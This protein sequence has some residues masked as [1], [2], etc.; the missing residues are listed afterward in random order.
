MADGSEDEVF[1]LLKPWQ[2]LICECFE[3]NF[4]CLDYFAQVFLR[5]VRHDFDIKTPLRFCHLQLHFH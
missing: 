5:I 4:E 3:V 2:R 1:D